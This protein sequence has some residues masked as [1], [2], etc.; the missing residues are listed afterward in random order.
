MAA[1]CAQ[2]SIIKGMAGVSGVAADSLWPLESP[3]PNP[4]LLVDLTVRRQPGLLEACDHIPPPR[5][6]GREQE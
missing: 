3:L 5:S 6:S 2:I 1:S 4:H